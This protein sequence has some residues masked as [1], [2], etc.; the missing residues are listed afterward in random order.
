MKC[1]A[2]VERLPQIMP[3][4]PKWMTDFEE[5]QNFLDFHRC[6]REPSNEKLTKPKKGDENLPTPA[7]DIQS[8][9]VDDGSA[10]GIPLAD[11]ITEDDRLD[12]R[13][14][15]NRCLSE[16][17]YLLVKKRRS[18]HAWGFPQL[19]VPDNEDSDKT[20]RDI[21]LS[22]LQDACGKQMDAFPVG[23]G[24]M[25]HIA[26]I[27]KEKIESKNKEG[28]KVFFFKSQHY[29]KGKLQLSKKYEEYVWVTKTQLGD[30]V[31][32]EYNAYL[33]HMLP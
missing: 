3:D 30:Y 16:R 2:V 32:P 25:G 4:E 12:V 14:S 6:R 7:V 13:T 26:Y 9:R 8:I 27:H 31:C 19:S 33:Q 22:A 1:A 11:R 28:S 21:A 17:L 5:V 10:Q 20:L 15:L 23:Y 24:P 18:E 29:E